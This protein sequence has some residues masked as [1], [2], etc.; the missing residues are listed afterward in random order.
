MRSVSPTSSLWLPT[1]APD[2][3]VPCFS[4]KLPLLVPSGAGRG[5]RCVRLAVGVCFALPTDSPRGRGRR[6]RR[7]RPKPS[8]A[9]RCQ[10]SLPRICRARFSASGGRRP[11]SNER[12]TTPRTTNRRIGAC[13][14]SRGL[15]FASAILAA[16]WTQR[17]RCGDALREPR[18]SFARPLG[19]RRDD[20]SRP[21]GRR[22]RRGRLLVARRVDRAIR[23]FSVDRVGKHR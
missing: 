20:D 17:G 15:R 10:T 9:V 5:L 18:E 16:T 13:F 7:S 3:F 22:A 12:G 21:C 19:A 2:W 14:A 1:P 11:L 4:Q 8:A 6:G 23:V